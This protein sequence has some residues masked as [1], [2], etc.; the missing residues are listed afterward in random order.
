MDFVLDENIREEI[1][2]FQLPLFSEIPDVGLYLN[3]TVTYIN[4]YFKPFAFL[5]ITESMVSNYVKNKL[6]TNPI[7]K[8]YSN[9]QIASLFLIT[10]SKSVIT[11]D[12]ISI[13]MKIEEE[14]DIAL[15]YDYFSEN[16][17]SRIKEIF[18]LKKESS[19][20]SFIQDTL[21]SSII[22]SVAH[23][24]YLETIFLSLGKKKKKNDKEKSGSKD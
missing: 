22:D 19:E 4:R 18:G 3:Q 10:I 7:K 11:L 8:Q 24:A 9:K 2:C 12:D 13:L 6:V 21:L 16:F 15:I 1:E 5:A 14:K 20:S 17:Q 23:K